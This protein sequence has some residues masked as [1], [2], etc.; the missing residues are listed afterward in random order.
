MITK[1]CMDTKEKARDRFTYD[2]VI[3]LKNIKHIL[4]INSIR[5]QCGNG[6]IIINFCPIDKI[7]LVKLFKDLSSS[8]VILFLLAIEYKLSP[9]LTI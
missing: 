1:I 9:F 5:Y 3:I 2:P 7:L 4:E 8:T 6:S